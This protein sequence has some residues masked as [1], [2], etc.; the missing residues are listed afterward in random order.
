[1]SIR[2]KKL[3]LD[4]LLAADSIAEFINKKTLEDFINHSMTRAA[5]ER[6]FIIIGEALKSGD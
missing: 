3:L 6:E 4:A 1:M 2:A 5:V